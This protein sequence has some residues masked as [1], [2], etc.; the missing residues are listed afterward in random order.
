MKVL[1]IFLILAVLLSACGAKGDPTAVPLFEE[2][3]VSETPAPTRT[4][5]PTAT[6][7]SI[8][9]SPS[10]AGLCT[11]GDVECVQ[12]ELNELDDIEAYLVES[13]SGLVTYYV[14]LKRPTGGASAEARVFYHSI[15]ALLQ[16][17]FEDPATVNVMIFI[18]GQTKTILY[19]QK[20]SVEILYYESGGLVGYQSYRKYLEAGR[21]YEAFR[22]LLS[23]SDTMPIAGIFRVLG[24]QVCVGFCVGQFTEEDSNVVSH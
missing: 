8:E 10:L 13:D 12:R 2:P 7:M 21:T 16:M 14:S 4:Q 19:G 18:L 23:Q 6:P 24:S 15:D 3:A 20:E 11:P 22:V 9:T 1:Y 17:G 5:R